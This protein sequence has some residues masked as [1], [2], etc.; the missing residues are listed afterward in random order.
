[1]YSGDDGETAII[2]YS[3]ID[4]IPSYISRLQALG[5]CSKLH[6]LVVNIHVLLYTYREIISM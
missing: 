6:I 5:L 1:M 2:S 3:I 4:W